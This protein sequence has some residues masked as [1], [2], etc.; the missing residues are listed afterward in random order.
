MKILDLGCGEKKVEGAVGLD[1]VALSDVDIAHDLLDFP[2]PIENESYDIIYLRNV[3][4]HFYLNDIEKILNECFRI[5][6][7]G[8][9]LYV[10]VPHAFSV[11]AFTDPTHKQFFTFGSGYFWDKKY[12][13]SYYND[14]DS[15]WELLNVEC[16]RITWFDWKEYQLKRLDGFLSAMMKKRI[17]RALQKVGNPSLADR[18]VK[19]YTFQFVEIRL[20]F[21]KE[22]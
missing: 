16:N 12:Q 17:N 14:I 11:S 7:L 22:N 5:L 20:S 15:C 18:I 9:M 6:V 10:T 19:K 1:N 8:G 4:E 21:Q 2:Y 3:I 13:K